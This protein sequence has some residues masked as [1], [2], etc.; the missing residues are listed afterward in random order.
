M[1]FETSYSEPECSGCCHE[2]IRTTAPHCSHCP[3]HGQTAVVHLPDEYDYSYLVGDPTKQQ[4]KAVHAVPSTEMLT[5]YDRVL[6]R[7][8]MHIL[9]QL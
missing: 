9:W 2:C 7:F 6:L 5:D 1:Q 4:D 8:G 3:Q